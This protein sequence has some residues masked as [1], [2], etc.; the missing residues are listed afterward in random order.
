MTGNLPTGVEG[1]GEM[2]GMGEEERGKGKGESGK[3]MTGRGHAWP[4]ITSAVLY[5]I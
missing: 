4:V 3:K 5:T 2:E 1:N